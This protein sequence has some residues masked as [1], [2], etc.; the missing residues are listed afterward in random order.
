M[1]GWVRIGN[2]EDLHFISQHLDE[3]GTLC[4]L[5]LR[6]RERRLRV[7]TH[8]WSCLALNDFRACYGTIML[9][10]YQHPGSQFLPAH[11]SFCPST[12]PSHSG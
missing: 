3:V 6:Q 12:C 5:V 10:C 2:K 4:S 9:P 8:R 11:L 1:Q 7:W